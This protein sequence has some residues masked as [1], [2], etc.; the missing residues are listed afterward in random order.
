MLDV[1][2]AVLLLKI[3]RQGALFTSTSPQH[4]RFSAI[5]TRD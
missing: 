1:V 3:L 4:G 5:D 2:A